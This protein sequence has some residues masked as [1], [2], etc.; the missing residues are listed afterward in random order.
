MLLYDVPSHEEA[1]TMI[2]NDIP[3]IEETAKKIAHHLTF[4][5]ACS[6]GHTMSQVVNPIFYKM[7]VNDHGFKAKRCLYWMWSMCQCLS[8]E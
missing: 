4:M 8:I 5:A 3:H 6:N 1:L 7:Y 2:K